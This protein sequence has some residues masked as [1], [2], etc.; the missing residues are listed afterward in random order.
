[1]AASYLPYLPDQDFLLPPSL[2]EW[3]PDGH[4]AHFI[5]DTVDDRLPIE[6][7]KLLTEKSLAGRLG[8][9]AGAILNRF[10]AIGDMWRLYEDALK[11]SKRL[12]NFLRSML[13]QMGG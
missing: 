6:I 4:L 7:E 11:C 3:L 9:A 13:P 8:T 5:S 2:G 12:A 10:S 1:M